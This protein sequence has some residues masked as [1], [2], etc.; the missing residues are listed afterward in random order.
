[1]QSV[2]SRIAFATSLTSDRDGIGLSI[3]DSRMSVAVITVFPALLQR[4]IIHFCNNG[5][6]SGSISTPRSPLATMIPS[7]ISNIAWKLLTPSKFSILEMMAPLKLGA[8]FFRFSTS[9]PFLVKERAINSQLLSTANLIDL[10]SFS[11]R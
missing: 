6:R 10:R 7:E 11:E 1:M 5:T 4:L 8:T 9:S 3:I 2:P